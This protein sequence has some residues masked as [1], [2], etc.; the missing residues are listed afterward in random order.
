MSQLKV[1]F[2][3]NVIPNPN[4]SQESIRF[5]NAEYLIIDILSPQLADDEGLEFGLAL[6][7]ETPLIGKIKTSYVP[8][9]ISEWQVG[10]TGDSRELIAIPRE[11]SESGYNLFCAIG[12]NE[13]VTLR[14][15][16]VISDTTKEEI[17]FTCDE[18]LAKVSSIEV[19]QNTNLALDVSQNVAIGII[20]TGLVPITGGVTSPVPVI[21]GKDL[22]VLLPAL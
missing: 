10:L 16:A 3:G 18:I 12:V 6:L 2:D 8:F 14:I 17:Q 22:P 19:K 11:F 20:G 4:A 9:K 21:V 13:P 7:M 5:T 15:Y 1:I